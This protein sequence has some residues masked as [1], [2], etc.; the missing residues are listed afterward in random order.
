M[1]KSID[2]GILTD[3]AF[4]VHLRSGEFAMDTIFLNQFEIPVNRCRRRLR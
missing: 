1:M 3:N 2:R 4:R